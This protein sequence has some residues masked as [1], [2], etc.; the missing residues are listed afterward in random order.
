MKDNMEE[1]ELDDIERFISNEK[2][3]TEEELKE[4]Q[5]ELVKVYNSLSA[6]LDILNLEIKDAFEKFDDKKWLS[7][8]NKKNIILQNLAELERI[9]RK[10]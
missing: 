9:I 4:V 8:T 2:D 10:R 7:L 5:E 6:Y 1:E 3:K